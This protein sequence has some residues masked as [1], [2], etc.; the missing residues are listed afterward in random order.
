M[1]S[2]KFPKKVTP[3]EREAAG[4]A[5]KQHPLL[6]YQ[7]DEFAMRNEGRLKILQL[8]IH[9]HLNKLSVP[10]DGLIVDKYLWH[11]TSTRQLLHFLFRTVIA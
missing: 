8:T 1:D 6:E 9:I 5:V 2:Q 10:T 7:N 3:D 4:V 11:C